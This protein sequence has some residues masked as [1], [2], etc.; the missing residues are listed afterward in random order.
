MSSTWPKVKLGEVVTH[1]KEFIE[2][3]DL[4]T[5]K[6][7]RVQLHAKGIVLRD[8]VE[9][10]RIRT[11]QQQV[12]RA[13]EFL[14]AEIDAKVGGFGL[15]PDELNGAI[16]SSHYFLFVPDPDKL[17]HRFLGYY[18]KT[19]MFRDQVEAQGSTNYAAIRPSH[20][21]GYTIPLPPLAEQRRIVAK[22]EALAEKIEEAQGLR[23]KTSRTIAHTIPAAASRVID[24]SCGDLVALGDLLREN[25]RNGLGARPSDIPTGTPILRISAGTSRP[26][27]LVD[28]NDHKYLDVSERE[29]GLYALQR[30]DLLACR[31]NGNLHY[32]GRFSLYAAESGVEQVYPDK[33]IRFRVDSDRVLP[34]YVRAVMNSPYGR[35]KI[36]EFCRTTAGNIGISATNLKSIPL[37]VPPLDDQ[38]RIVEYLDGIQAKVDEL[39]ALQGKTQKELDALLPSVLDKAFKGELV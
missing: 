9:G 24:A 18:A 35:G 26:D 4:K 15:V 5:Y 27:G 7:C 22:I 21:L 28:E 16:V 37:P 11:K 34:E 20:V 25:S 29:R 19:P 30:G 31:F 2:I 12:C 32:V 6:R 10:A 23:V 3:D 1:R 33:L 17:D 8:Q 36:E 38:Y 13:N 39:K 14:V